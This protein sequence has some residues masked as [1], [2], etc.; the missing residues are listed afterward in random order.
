MKFFRHATN[1]KTITLYPFVCWHV[2]APQADYK[3]I[4]EMVARLK[5]DPHGKGIY[6]GDGGECVT[7]SSKGMIYTQTMNPQEQVNWLVAK[8]API[9]HKL[10]FGVRGN[11]GNRTFKDSGLGFDDCLCLGLQ[12]PYLGTAAFMRLKVHR[13]SY[14]V[15][16]HHGL[17]SGV[18][19]GT[20]INKAKK[21]EEVIIADAIFSAHSHICAVIP[22]H[23]R[24]Y[25]LENANDGGHPIRWITT[26]GYICGC[27]YDSRSGYAEDKGY[28]PLLPGHLSVTFDGHRHGDLNAVK[29][30][31]YQLYHRGANDNHQWSEHTEG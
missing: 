14:S 6:M 22:P 2:G 16:V 24:A 8:L 28:P 13:T 11:H 17:D 18:A 4:D 20:K 25:L 29:Q 1:E 9:R 27:A 19:I 30:Q 15:F 5:D 3:F 31:T 10:L 12:I 23:H 7:R 21:F 26:H